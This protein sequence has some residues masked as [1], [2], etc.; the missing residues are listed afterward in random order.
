MIRVRHVMAEAYLI[1]K[2]EQGTGI[3]T[4]VIDACHQSL[5]SR[6]VNP[7]WLKYSLIALITALPNVID[8]MLLRQVLLIPTVKSFVIMGWFHLPRL[9]LG[10][11][12]TSLASALAARSVDVLPSFCFSLALTASFFSHDACI[13]PSK[14][15]TLLSDINWKSD[16]AN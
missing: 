12:Q 2:R 14:T 6:Y 8:V 16:K 7:Y 10:I 15:D 1:L 5:C 4:C 13:A 9:R 3:F 11:I